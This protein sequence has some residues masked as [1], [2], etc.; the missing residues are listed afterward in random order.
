VKFLSVKCTQTP[1]KAASHHAAHNSTPYNPKPQMTHSKRTMR[2]NSQFPKT[3]KTDEKDGKHAVSRKK[4]KKA[5][6]W[7]YTP[8]KY[9][10]QPIPS[11]IHDQAV[12]SYVCN[13]NKP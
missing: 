12:S 7:H 11:V 10:L 1:F 2:R 8:T 6:F 9:P 4:T 3:E 5:E 13:V